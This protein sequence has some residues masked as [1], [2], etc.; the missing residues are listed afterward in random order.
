MANKPGFDLAS[1]LKNVSKLD[2][3]APSDRDA[4]TYIDIDLIDDDPKNFYELSGLEGLA[5]NIATCGLQQPIRVRVHPENA[6]RYMIVSGHRRR[7]AIR[8]LIADGRE[9]LREIPCIIDRRTGSAALQELCL[10]YGN[11]NTR[12]MTSYE[13]SQQAQRVEALLYQLKEEGYAFPGRMRDHVAEACKISTGKL[14]RLKVI[15]ENLIPQF[16][17]LWESGKLRESVAYTLAGHTPVR[18]KAVW[19]AQTD[20]GKK[21]FRCTDGWCENVFREMARVEKECKKISCDAR[22]DHECVHVHTR[23]NHAAGLGQYNGLFCTKCCK[24][25]CILSSCRFSCGYADA[26]KK[27]Q[28]DAEKTKRAQEKAEQKAKDEPEKELLRLAYSRVGQLRKEK[29]ISAEDFVTASLGWHYARD[30]ERL[31]KME[32]GS[33]ALTDR[34]PGSIWPDEAKHLRDTADLL[35]CSIDYLLGR[36]EQ[37]PEQQECVNIDIGWRMGTP[38]EQGEYVVLAKFTPEGSYIPDRYQWD[39]SAWIDFET[40]VENVGISV[41]YWMPLPKNQ[42]RIAPDEENTSSSNSCKTG[43]SGSGF[44]GSASYCEEPYDCCLQCDKDCNGRCGWID[45]EE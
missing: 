14:A 15:R 24:E 5:D 44:C 19:E 25:C 29:G 39:G 28:R 11:A 32:A 13:V 42:F 17:R 38:S 18:Q 36:D 20:G 21:E 8:V 12:T 1:A 34:M 23:V 3:G 22:P 7:A 41:D 6:D 27:E 30:I 35:G 37:A 9:D 33:V 31:E 45:G 40:D 10:I 43:M 2:T 26:E 16:M 4:I